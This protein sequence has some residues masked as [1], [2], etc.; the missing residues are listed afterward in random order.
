MVIHRAKKESIE[1]AA[2]AAAASA[3][4]HRIMKMR[5]AGMGEIRKRMTPYLLQP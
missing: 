5:P 3:A 2:A 1:T 4:K